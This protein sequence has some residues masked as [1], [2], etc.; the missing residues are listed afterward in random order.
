[1]GD[2]MQ[3]RVGDGSPSVGGLLSET[4]QFPYCM[5]VCR[6]VETSV[7]TTVILYWHMFFYRYALSRRT[8]G[9]LG[10]QREGV[11]AN[12]NTKSSICC[13]HPI[14]QRC[15]TISFSVFVVSWYV[16]TNPTR[17]AVCRS[18]DTHFPVTIQPCIV[19]IVQY[20]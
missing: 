18:R 15:C 12:T 2:V 16:G 4:F 7:G 17:P 20:E 10:L 6:P 13:R 1:M 11:P 19:C 5:Y 14:Y 9:T 3:V 8:V